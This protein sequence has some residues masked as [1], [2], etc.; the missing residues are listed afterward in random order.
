MTVR[1]LLAFCQPLYPTWD[2]VLCRRLLSLLDLPDDRRMSQLS[3]GMRMKAALVA[4]LA[5]R[6]RLLIIDEPFNGLDPL[7]RDD[8]ALAVRAL[9]TEHPLSVLISSHDLHE[10]EAPIDSVAY[11]QDG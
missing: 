1:Q 2:P 6:P 8:V 11:V 7:M 4:S 5:Y 10:F 3:R 9:A